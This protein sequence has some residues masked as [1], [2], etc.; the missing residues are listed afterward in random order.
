MRLTG[1]LIMEVAPVEMTL[2]KRKMKMDIIMVA[3]R[4]VVN[5]NEKNKIQNKIY[6]QL[7]LEFV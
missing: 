3:K 2:R 5:L 4:L 7:L 1:T 6:K